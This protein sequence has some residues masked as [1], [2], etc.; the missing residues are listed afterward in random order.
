LFELL[1]LSILLVADVLG[2]GGIKEQVADG[3]NQTVDTKG[4]NG[5]QNVATGSGG[6]ALGLQGRMVDNKAAD[7]TQKEGQKKA[8]EIVVVIHDADSFLEMMCIQYIMPKP[9]CQ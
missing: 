2:L 7:P 8:D 4:N 9:F 5:E 3:G 1:L 6:V